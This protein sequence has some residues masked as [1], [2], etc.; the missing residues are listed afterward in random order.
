MD[1]DVDRPVEERPLDLPHEYPLGADG[2]EGGGARTIPGSGDDRDLGLV[3]ETLEPGGRACRL[4]A[5]QVGAAGADAQL[6]VWV[7]HLHRIRDAARAA[8]AAGPRPDSR[9]RTGPGSV[10]ESGPY[11]ASRPMLDRQSS[12]RHSMGVKSRW[13]THSGRL[14]RRMWLSTRHRLR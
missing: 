11:A 6:H 14:K 12:P 5:R 7:S 3:A 13:A 2:G 1:R 8:R 4:D 10:P 9:R